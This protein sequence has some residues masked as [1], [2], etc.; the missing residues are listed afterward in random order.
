MTV[1]AV[2]LLI[3]KILSQYLVINPTDSNLVKE[4]KEVLK[5]H[6]TAEYSKCESSLLLNKACFLDPRFKSLSYLEEEEKQ[7]VIKAIEL[8]AMNMVPTDMQEK[9]AEPSAKKTKSDEIGIMTLIGDMV[10]LSDNM[11]MPGDDF[12]M[13]LQKYSSLEQIKDDPLEWWKYN[14]TKFP[15]LSKLAK[16]YLAIPGLCEPPKRAFDSE[17]CGSFKNR[18]LW[19]HQEEMDIRLFLAENLK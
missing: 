10:E 8:E 16:Q 5:A 18:R 3:H 6:L 17:D 1:A 12:Q 13:E 7:A 4:M 19:L 11:D 15:V 14:E 9:T 2:R